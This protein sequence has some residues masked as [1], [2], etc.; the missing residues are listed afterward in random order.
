MNSFSS[1]ISVGFETRR[2]W[3]FNAKARS[4]ARFKRTFLGNYWLGLSNLVSSLLLVLVYGT[5]FQVTNFREYSVYILL[6]LT[7]WNIITT[8]VGSAPTLLESNRDSLHNTDLPVIVYILQEWAFNLRALFQTTIFSLF[9]VSL[10]NI[11]YL[12]NIWVAIPGYVL[13]IVTLF[14]L[15][16]L[17][18]LC[19]AR[20]QDLYQLI[21]VLILLTFLVSPI[22]Y[23]ETKLQS[24]S[25]IANF[26]P[27]Y[28]SISLVRDS[29]IEGVFHP[30]KIIFLTFFNLIGFSV[31]VQTYKTLHFKVK[32]MT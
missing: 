12:L 1:L 21:P 10:I 2:L 5:V 16:A 3:W 18:C 15:P 6:G 28:L 24:L 20:F 4:D 31:F 27:I 19:G 17:V 11:H 29:L 22:L 7:C 32:F 9:V 14:W 23:Y 30:L 25:F 8:A 26:N 13:L